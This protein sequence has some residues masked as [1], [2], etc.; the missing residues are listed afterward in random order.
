MAILNPDQQRLFVQTTTP[1]A[2]AVP[3]STG[4]A[5][6][7]TADGMQFINCGFSADSNAIESR[8]RS[9]SLGDLPPRRGRRVASYELEVPLQGSG[10]AG[11]VP[12]ID[13]ILVALFGAAGSVS[14]GVSVTYSIAAVNIGLTMWKFKDP[15]GT[16]APNQVAVGGLINDFE[17]SGGEEAESS[18]IVR[19]P[20][21]DVIEKPNF[22]SL[23]TAEKFGLT[24]FPSEPSA[25]SFLGT[26]ALAFT[27]SVTINGV[28]TFPLQRFRIYGQF[29][30]SIRYA[31]G[32]YSVT[33][34]IN[35]K[36]KIFYDFSLYE[37]DTANQAALRHLNRT[38]GNFDGSIVIGDT[39]GNTW[40][41]ALNNAVAGNIT[42][43]SSGSES[44]LN[45]G[46][47]KTSITNASSND[48]LSLVCT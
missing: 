17:I 9:G 5:T 33:V 29:N 19:G 40:T 2:A 47:C 32:L 23:T 21:C 38:K 3:N 43:D 12:D 16:N 1:W 39:A 27:G 11:T 48:E 18:L 36:R 35:N 4:S 41:F 25:T 31:H 20:L 46:S 13:Q 6:V 44:I 26:P 15:A 42:E 30:R 8:V 10:T 22:S 28:S 45:F 7:A 37:E 24:S 14:A 34:P